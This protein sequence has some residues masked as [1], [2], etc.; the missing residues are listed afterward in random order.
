VAFL[1]LFIAWEEFLD[2]S[3]EEYLFTPP[4][5]TA[6]PR[7]VIRASNRRC[8]KE[9]I[10]GERRQFVEWSDPAAVRDRAAIFFE[11]GEPYESVLSLIL[12]HLNRM[13]TVRNRTVHPSQ[14]AEDKFLKM[15]RELYGRALQMTPGT[16]LREVPPGPLMPP[17]QPAVNTS[18]FQLF[19]QI[20]MAG[21]KRIIP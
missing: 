11:D 5:K 13:K 10:L 14:Y 17:G 21:A 6:K 18:V 7:I 20:L 2:A 19:A 8:A 3:F 15:I 12:I 4:G 1:R 16:F 9:L